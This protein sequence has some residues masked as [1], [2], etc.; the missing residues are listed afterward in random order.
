[1]RFHMHK[2]GN[3]NYPNFKHGNKLYI[4]ESYYY[5]LFFRLSGKIEYMR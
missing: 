5:V 1:M 2:L 3:V 4:Y